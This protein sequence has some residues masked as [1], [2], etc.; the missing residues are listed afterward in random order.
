MNVFKRYLYATLISISLG[1]LGVAVFNFSV[2]PYAIYRSHVTSQ[3]LAQRPGAKIH[4]RLHKVHQV[5]KIKPQTLILGN[6]RVTVGYDPMDPSFPYPKVYNFGLDGANLHEIFHALKFVHQLCPL[7]QVLLGLDFTS[8]NAFLKDK[9]DFNED[10]YDPNHHYRH[11]EKLKL[12]LAVSTLKD[13]LKTLTNGHD[14]NYPTLTTQGFSTTQALERY[15]V[16]GGGHRAISLSSEKS[17][18]KATWFPEPLHQYHFLDPQNAYSSLD[19]FAQIIE[20]CHQNQIELIGVISPVHARLRL[21]QS[22]VHLE[23]T[24]KQWLKELVFINEHTAKLANA[25]AFLI[26]DFSG[27]EPLHQAPF[28]SLGDPDTSMD[29]YWEASHFKKELGHQVLRRIFSKSTA[30]GYFGTRLTHETLFSHL[31]RL[32]QSKSQY[33]AH[34]PNVVEEITALLTDG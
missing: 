8:F 31:H 2:D 27:F 25:P 7:K 24:F 3:T 6:S 12:L 29:F 33:M 21:A 13:S 4:E 23:G 15:R 16:K 18:M 19:T 10:R 32:D 34:H 26:W 22:L 20:Y 30:L 28:P 1:F 5:L 17:Y 11:L 14:L 9:P